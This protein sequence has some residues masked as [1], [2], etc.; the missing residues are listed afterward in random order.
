VRIFEVSSAGKLMGNMAISSE[1]IPNANP[2]QNHRVWAPGPGPAGRPVWTYAAVVLLF[3]AG[4]FGL[5][6]WV[7]PLLFSASSLVW[8]RILA[9]G[10]V[11]MVAALSAYL[12]LRHVRNGERRA[13]AAALARHR[14]EEA[15]STA[16]LQLA[17]KHREE[18]ELDRSQQ[19]LQSTLDAFSNHIVILDDQGTI[20]AVN[21]SW[22][23][24]VEQ[25]GFAGTGYGIGSKYL[26]FVI[27]SGDPEPAAAGRGLAEVLEGQVEGFRRLY[28]CAT[29]GA[30]RWFQLQVNP[31]TQSEK[32]RFLVVQEDVTEFKMAQEAQLDIDNRILQSREEERRKIARELHDSTVQKI[33]GVVLNLTGI[34]TLLNNGEKR[35]QHLLTET[36][37]LGQECMQELRSISYL[38]RPPLPAGHDFLPALNSYID[39][40]CKRSGIR[41]NLVLPAHTGRMPA[42]VENALFRVVQET[43]SNIHRHSQSATATVL[44][45]KN[46]EQ[47]ILEVKDKG[48]GMPSPETAIYRT[49]AGGLAGLEERVHEL[50]GSLSIKSANPGTAVKAAIPLNGPSG[51]RG[52]S[53]QGGVCGSY[54]A[55]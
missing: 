55:G 23:R 35:V 34:K 43:L 48:K 28:P 27:R 40:F 37:S 13:L 32:K 52:V 33:L 53:A 6:A 54:S 45:H 17:Q 22:R 18:R 31:F 39:G 46:E 25:S 24:F 2:Q 26:D 10:A 29:P 11:S 3:T 49:T 4:S 15:G 41:V 5:F 30:R 1:A 8:F 36:L 47:V 19:L 9:P 51:Q 44:L 7:P 16:G 38:L 20:I 42:N 12:A 50:G 14:R 21:Q